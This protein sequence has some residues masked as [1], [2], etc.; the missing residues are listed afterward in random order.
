MAVESIE[1]TAEIPARPERVFRA[2]LSAK[3]HA[4]FTGGAAEIEAKER[5]RHTA[6]DGYI[7]G[8][9]LTVN[10]SKHRFVQ[11]WRTT[12]FAPEHRDSVVS[13]RISRAKGG[14]L[15]TLSHSDIPEG[16]GARYLKGWEDF[17]FEPLRKYFA[18]A[19]KPAKK[20]KKAIERAASESKK[21]AKKSAEKA[22]KKSSKKSAK[23]ASKK[24][25]KKS[26]KKG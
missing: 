21:S 9:N 7:H 10:P 6:Y 25:A 1:L 11:S 19:E 26:S 3:E 14:A 20:V 2:W 22:S 5:S 23:K 12:E 24:S 15:V 13:V 4:A 17:Y 18:S 8:W 16:Q